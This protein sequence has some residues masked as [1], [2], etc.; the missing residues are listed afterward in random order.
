MDQPQLTVKTLTYQLSSQ[1]AQPSLTEYVEHWRE[2]ATANPTLYRYNKTTGHIYHKGQ[3]L[4][5]DKKR[6]D[7]VKLPHKD[8]TQLP[9][10]NTFPLFADI[11]N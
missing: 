11:V 10:S 3:A 8:Q 5:F 6:N 7:W 4:V 1:F 9:Y 2:A